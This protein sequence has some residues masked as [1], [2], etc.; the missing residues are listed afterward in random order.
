MNAVAPGPIASHRLEE[1]PEQ[2]RV[3]IAAAVPLG[4]SGTVDEVAALVA[5]LASDQASF[6]TGAVIPIDG[7]KTAT[8]A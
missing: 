4:R 2:V 6:I 7:G 5:W 8:G 1:L 3:G